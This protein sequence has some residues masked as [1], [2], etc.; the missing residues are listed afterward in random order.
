MPCLFVL[1]TCSTEPFVA[2]VRIVDDQS[3]TRIATLTKLTCALP[4]SLS[5]L[6]MVIE[7]FLTLLKCLLHRS[8][9]ILGPTDIQGGFTIVTKYLFAGA[10]KAVCTAFVTTLANVSF[11]HSPCQVPYD[12]IVTS[13]LVK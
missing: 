7:A 10:C 1:F 12:V 6:F 2:F 11:G 9:G 3:A 8:Q 13:N 4:F 5:F